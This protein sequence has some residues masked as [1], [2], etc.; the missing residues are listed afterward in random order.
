MADAAEV[1]RAE[2]RF[3]SVKSLAVAG[4]RQEDASGLRNFTGL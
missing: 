1:D 3:I 2:A 4:L